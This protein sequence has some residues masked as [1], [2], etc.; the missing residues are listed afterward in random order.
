M[1]IIGC[2]FHPSGQQVFM[3]ESASGEVLADRW[4]EHQGE[5]VKKFYASLPAGAVV[6]VEASGNMVWFERLLQSYGHELWIGDAVK[7]R[8]QDER[9]Q[10][11]DRRDA[12]LIAR[13]IQEGRFPR[14]QWVPSLGERDL[15][16]LLLHRHKLVRLRAQIKCQ[17]QHIAINQGVQRKHKLWT[18]KGREVLES[19]ELEPWTQRRRDDLL[20]LMEDVGKQCWELDQAVLV[21]AEANVRARLLMSHPGVGPVISLAM[22]LTVGK[23]ERFPNSRT[24]VSYLGLNPSEDSSGERRRQ[25]AISKQGNSFMR[26]LLVQGAQTAARTDPAWKRQYKRLAM[27]KHR[28]LAKV[29]IARKLAVR[30]YWMLRT[31]TPYPEV[32]RMQGSSS[33]PV[34][35]RPTSLSERPASQRRQ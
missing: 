8:K 26:Y 27:R 30:L 12:E 4:I 19:L 34:V 21:A 7:I 1:L 2:D 31:N 20:R 23:V 28:A 16:Q 29:M 22:V 18:Q 5:E 24:L 13:L 15:R 14:L 11:T 32:V 17:L 25:G 3:V 35:E 10:K 6:G 9:K 33:H